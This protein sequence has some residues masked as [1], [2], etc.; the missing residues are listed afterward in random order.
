MMNLKVEPDAE[1]EQGHYYRS[2]HFSFARAGV[3][4]FSIAQGTDYIGKP[5]GFGKE[6]FEKYN[7]EH[8]HQP[9]DE[10][11][12]DWDFSGMQQM[13]DFGLRLGMDIANQ[14]QLPT[15]HA[16]DEFLKAREK[17]GVSAGH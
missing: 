1:P 7:A 13:A 16:G 5:A 14:P 8:Y 15:W 9:S 2:D 11:H 4:A 3:P 6:I 12:A 10:Y 17:S